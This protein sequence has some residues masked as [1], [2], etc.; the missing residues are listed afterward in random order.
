VFQRDDVGI[1]MI[2]HGQSPQLLRMTSMR[3]PALP[4][5]GARQLTMRSCRTN[6]AVLVAAGRGLTLAV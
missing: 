4:T 1:P 2:L 5:R 3:L 6:A